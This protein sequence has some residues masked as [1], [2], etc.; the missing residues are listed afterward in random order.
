MGE[1]KETDWPFSPGETKRARFGIY[2]YREV[3]EALF[4]GIRFTLQEGAKVV[5]S[6]II[7]EIEYN[8]IDEDYQPETLES[9]TKTS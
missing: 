8:E 6:A 4:V 2:G 9:R 1:L 7:E 3:C 5:G